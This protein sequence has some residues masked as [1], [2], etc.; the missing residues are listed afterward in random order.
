MRLGNLNVGLNVQTVAI[1]AAALLLGPTIIAM[2]GGLA[3]ALAK[4]GIKG[5][6]LA[7]EKGKELAAETKETLEDLTAEAKAEVKQEIKAVPAKKK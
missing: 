3:R 1:G 7:L 2:A 5:G 4:S 6:L